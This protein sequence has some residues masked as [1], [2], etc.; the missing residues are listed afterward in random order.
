MME[1]PQGS[2]GELAQQPV[3]IQAVR[4]AFASAKLAA[5]MAVAGLA[6]AQAATSA[7]SACI[8]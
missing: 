4:A 5:G 7:G 3:D 6:M 8:A 1:K 2:A